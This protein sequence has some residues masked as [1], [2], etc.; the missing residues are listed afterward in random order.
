MIKKISENSPIEVRSTFLGAHAVPLEYKGN[1]SG[2]LDLLINELLPAIAAEKLADYCD[3]FCEENYFD[4]KDCIR[5]FEASHKYNIQPKV[6]SEQLSHTGG[7]LAGVQSNAISVDHLEFIDDNDIE[8]LKNSATMP[9][10]YRGL[11]YF[12]V[13]KNLPH[14]K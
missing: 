6:H 9:V 12:L 13:Y 3:I 8:K 4:F 7:I 14:V 11:N 2:Y 1:K 10:I 5:L